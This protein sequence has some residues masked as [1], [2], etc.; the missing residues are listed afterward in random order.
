MISSTKDTTDKTARK[1]RVAMVEMLCKLCETHKQVVIDKH[2]MV[3]VDQTTG[4][5]N[6]LDVSG[7]LTENPEQNNMCIGKAIPVG[8]LTAENWLQMRV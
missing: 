2:V 6:G 8:A 3:D 4:H 7:L 5:I 1:L